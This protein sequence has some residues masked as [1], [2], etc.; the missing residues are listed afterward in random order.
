MAFNYRLCV[1]KNAGNRIP[2]T[3]PE[4]YDPLRYETTARFL[5][6]VQN[7]GIPVNP[8]H[9]IG[10]GDTVEGKLDVNS[11]RYFSTNVW[12]IGYD[13]ATGTESKRNQI[14]A[15]VRNHIQGL[16]WFAQSDPRVP[17]TVRD[18]T[19]SF[20]YCA[21]EFTDNG[22]FPRQMYVRQA[23]RLIGQFVLTQNDLVK[24]T[25]FND[26]IGL[27][28]YPMDEHGMIRTVVNGYVADETRESIGVGPYEIPYRAMLPKKTQVTN[29]IVPVAISA[30]HSAFTSVRVEPT[31]MVLGQ[32]A[33]AAAALAPN[34][35]VNNINVSKL[36]S[37]L[38]EH[39]QILKYDN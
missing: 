32:A 13:Y 17:K 2:F 15:M 23:R 37:T 1:T 11:T 39:K 14:S 27:G 34:G 8:A 38:K 31:F 24:K 10:G 20:G 25:T 19:A 3:R 30:S 6:A 22:G 5:A 35:N 18:Y 16:M 4:G 29:L 28:Y 7:A 21:D 33:G 36:R 26:T 12:H 9:F